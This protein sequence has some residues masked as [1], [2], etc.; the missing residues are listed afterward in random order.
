MIILYS[1]NK[2]ATNLLTIFI[3][4]VH[5]YPTWVQSS[6]ITQLPA[7]LPDPA[8][9]SSSRVHAL[10]DLPS[11]SPWVNSSTWMFR[12]ILLDSG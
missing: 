7:L 2:L 1:L 4:S 12:C 11:R 6:Q 9:L 10:P 3:L 8:G 5:C